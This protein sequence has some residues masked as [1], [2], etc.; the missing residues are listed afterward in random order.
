MHPRTFY[1]FTTT[2][3]K[4]RSGHIDVTTTWKCS[5]GNNRNNSFREGNTSSQRWRGGSWQVVLESVQRGYQWAPS[6]LV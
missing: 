3:Q 1:H 2:Q 6:Q 5:L 4:K